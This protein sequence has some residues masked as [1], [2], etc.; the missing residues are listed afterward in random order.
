M[1][2]EESG[3]NGN[4]DS[5][6][7]TLYA[8]LTTLEKRGVLDSKLTGHKVSRPAEVQRGEAPDTLVIS[9]ESFSVFK[10]NPIAK[11]QNVKSSNIAGYIGLRALM[12]SKYIQ[13]VWRPL[14]RMEFM[15]WGL[16]SFWFELWFYEKSFLNCSCNILQLLFLLRHEALCTWKGNWPS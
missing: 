8:L 3:P 2:L 13:M 7:M 1:V 4:S 9:H 5:N 6:P 10:P 11:V 14:D 12:T 16:D 15:V